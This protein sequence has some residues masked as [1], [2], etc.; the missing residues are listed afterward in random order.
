MDYEPAGEPKK[1]Y[2][3]LS[4]IR[5]IFAIFGILTMLFSGGCSVVVL[6]GFIM[7]GRGDPSTT[8][9]IL[10]IGGVPFLIGLA[11]WWLAAK[12]GRSSTPGSDQ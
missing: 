9:L 6:G 1:W 7:D 10:V 4:V 5:W 12:V 2:N 8:A 3:D 11:V